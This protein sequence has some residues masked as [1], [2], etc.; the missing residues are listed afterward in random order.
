M[1]LPLPT[2]QWCFSLI[3]SATQKLHLC[4]KCI[5][6][7]PPPQPPSDS[8]QLPNKGRLKPNLIHLRSLLRFHRPHPRP[9][10]RNQL[11]RCT[12]VR[13]LSPQSACQCLRLPPH[14][15]AGSWRSQSLVISPTGPSTLRLA[16]AGLVGSQL[17][18]SEP[19]AYIHGGPRSSGKPNPGLGG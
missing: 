9:P 18:A 15:A 1:A 8:C 19:D 10:N 3:I 4:L 13:P 12:E 5:P 7:F 16:P 14:Q 2:Y 11:F 6:P 17:S